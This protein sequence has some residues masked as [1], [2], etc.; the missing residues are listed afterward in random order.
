MIAQVPR[1]PGFLKARVQLPDNLYPYPLHDLLQL[2]F[3]IYCHKKFAWR[4]LVK[5]AER[6][7]AVLISSHSIKMTTKLY[8]NHHCESPE[9]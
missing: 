3:S 6:V 4:C 7:N 8:N 1:H 5:M 2:D 9:E